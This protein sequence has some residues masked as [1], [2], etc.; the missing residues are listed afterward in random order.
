MWSIPITIIG[1][2]E[3]F[4]DFDTILAVSKTKVLQDKIFV[5]VYGRRLK[6]VEAEKS[7]TVRQSV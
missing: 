7:R 2:P 1:H 3:D 4:E 6:L 5:F